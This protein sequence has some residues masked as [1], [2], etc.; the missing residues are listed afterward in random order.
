M[1][2]SEITSIK[3]ETP[4]DLQAVALKHRA[5]QAASRLKVTKQQKRLAGIQK[6]LAKLQSQQ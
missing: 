1:R 6:S 4:E 3:P 5:D 2:I